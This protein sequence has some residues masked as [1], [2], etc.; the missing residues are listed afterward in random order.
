MIPVVACDAMVDLLF[1]IFFI[2]KMGFLHQH[3]E[4]PIFYGCTT[5]C[6]IFGEYGD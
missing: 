5:A 6:I 2:L 1:L 4:M 3:G